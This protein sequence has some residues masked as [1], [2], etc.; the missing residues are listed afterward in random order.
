ME[1]ETPQGFI[2]PMAYDAMR[3][4][5][6]L[7]VKKLCLYRESMASSAIEGDETSEVLLETIRRIIEG[8]PVSDRYLLGLAWF[9]INAEKQEK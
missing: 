7:G 4:V 6:S 5:K 1:K 3:Y 8:E 9:L 2:H